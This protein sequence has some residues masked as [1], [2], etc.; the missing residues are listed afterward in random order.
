[1]DLALSI[2]FRLLSNSREAHPLLLGSALERSAADQL[3][4]TETEAKDETSWGKPGNQKKTQGERQNL[5]ENE[6]GV[7]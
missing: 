5:D 6:D 1:M 2:D 3:Q 4:S 7:M